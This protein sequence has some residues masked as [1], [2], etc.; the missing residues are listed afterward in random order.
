MSFSTDSTIQNVKTLVT[1]SSLT[2]NKKL[3]HRYHMN[4]AVYFRN[5]LAGRNWLPS[6]ILHERETDL[7][8]SLPLKA[9]NL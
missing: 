5:R 7:H 1:P 3:I 9:K 6:I 2:Q 4:N 8:T